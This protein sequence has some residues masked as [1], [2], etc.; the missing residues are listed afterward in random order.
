MKF[1][2]SYYMKEHKFWHDW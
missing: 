1:N 2:D